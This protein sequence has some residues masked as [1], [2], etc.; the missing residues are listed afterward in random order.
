MRTISH[1]E[2]RA[3][4][5]ETL[6][7]VVDD[8]EEVVIT[9]AGHDAVVMVALDDYESLQETAYLLR[10]PD[11]ARRLLGAIERLERDG[12]SVHELIEDTDDTEDDAHR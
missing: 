3:R 11:N 1:S 2:S 8:R 6:N 10:S 9:R 4:Y 7:A 5:A 12:G